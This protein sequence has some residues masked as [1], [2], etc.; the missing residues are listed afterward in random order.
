MTL[1]GLRKSRLRRG[2]EFNFVALEPKPLKADAGK[3]QSRQ[4]FDFES[5]MGMDDLFAFISGRLQMN[6]RKLLE[7]IHGVKA[8]E[9]K[10]DR[11][12]HCCGHHLL[13]H[14]HH[15]RHR[16]LCYFSPYAI[17]ETG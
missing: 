7:T 2:F 14:P 1:E 16:S 11:G 5:P 3:V 12:S 17:P 13:A 15:P 8:L 10:K 4:R 9:P 6:P